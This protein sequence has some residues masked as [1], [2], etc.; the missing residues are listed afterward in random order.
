LG[1]R[2]VSGFLPLKELESELHVGALIDMVVV[3]TTANGRICTVSADSAKFATSHVGLI[4]LEFQPIVTFL[5]SFPKY[6][7]PHQS[8]PEP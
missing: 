1:V 4:D 2:D 3:K 6:H 8:S 7:Q 5:N